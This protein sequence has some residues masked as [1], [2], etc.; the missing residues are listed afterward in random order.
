VSE[1]PVLFSFGNPPYF[2][3]NFDWESLFSSLE[4]QPFFITQ[5]DRV[6]PIAESGYPWPPMHLSGGQE[7]SRSSLEKYL[8]NFY[9]KASN[10]DYLTASA[11]PGFHDIYNE[12]GVGPSYGYLDSEKGETL[13]FT[14]KKALENNPDIIQVVTWNDYGEGTNIEPTIEYGYQYLEMIQ[15]IKIEFVDEDF[16]YSPEDL[17]IPLQIFNLRKDF[18]G[19]P[20]VNA[21]LDDAV[22]AVHAGRLDIAHAILADY[23]KDE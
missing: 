4:T 22:S 11:F 17:P 20:Q 12:A 9:A 6:V 7:L 16:S 19:N 10:W 2:N 1:R 21:H 13:E 15:K 18:A 5:D 14:F 8:N 23:F 3:S